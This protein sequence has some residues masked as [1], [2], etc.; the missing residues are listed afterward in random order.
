[1]LC[2]EKLTI[3]IIDAVLPKCSAKYAESQPRIRK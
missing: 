1:M 2:P 3:Q